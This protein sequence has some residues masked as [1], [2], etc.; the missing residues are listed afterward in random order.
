MSD[1]NWAEVPQNTLA[2]VVT[3]QLICAFVFAY[4]KSRFFAHDVKS[5]FSL[6]VRRPVSR[7][8]YLDLMLETECEIYPAQ[9]CWHFNIYQQDELPALMIET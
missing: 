7:V 8:S 3:A 1:T 9:K 2:T 6:I 5:G 4:V